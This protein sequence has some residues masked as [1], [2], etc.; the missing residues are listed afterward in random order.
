MSQ[1]AVA[2]EERGVA[3]LVDG[4]SSSCAG[5]GDE[6]LSPAPLP[7]LPPLALS[8]FLGVL[9]TPTVCVGFLVLKSVWLT[10]ASLYYLWVVAPAAVCYVWNGARVAC[11]TSWRWGLR[12]ARMQLLLA[13]PLMILVVS[14]A[15]GG[16]HLLAV[17]VLHLDVSLIR[18]RLATYG[19]TQTNPSGDMGAL[20]WLTLLNPLMEEGFWR[21]F[22]F[23]LLLL[24]QLP[25]PKL[26]S[27]DAADASVAGAAASATNAGGEVGE[28]FSSVPSSSSSVGQW[29]RAGL[30]T[31]ALYAAYHVPI[32][33]S[34]LPFG[35]CVA[36][37]LGLVA[38]G[39]LLQLVVERFGVVLAILLHA[40][41]DLT[42]SLLIADIIFGWGILG[43]EY[44]R[45]F[46]N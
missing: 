21:I 7:Q 39:V 40:A 11:Y 35:L 16:A 14:G 46:R 26:A 8:T 19:L 27:V 10:Y 1:Q 30:L 42:A 22:L 28:R 2:D 24:R 18:A 45:P 25:T 32:V 5:G 23:N 20:A 9:V 43:G 33:W 34:C 29:W 36:A 37:Y 17:P 4:G 12:N 3:R 44:G 41:V 15:V 6:S 38:L 13:V 31:S